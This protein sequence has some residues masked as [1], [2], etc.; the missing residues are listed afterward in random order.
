MKGKKKLVYLF[1]EGKK[2]DKLLLGGKGANLAGGSGR[3]GPK[4]HVGSD[5]Q[6]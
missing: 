5:D 2:E 6:I 1:K 3:N 4:A